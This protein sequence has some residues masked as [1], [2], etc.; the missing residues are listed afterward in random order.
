MPELLDI[1]FEAESRFYVRKLIDLANNRNISCATSRYREQPVSLNKNQISMIEVGLYQVESES[2]PGTFYSVCITSGTCEC[3]QGRNRGP[4]KH[5]AAIH[6]YYGE[7][8]FNV[9]P[10]HDPVS[11]RLWNF[12]A[13]GKWLPETWF[14][15]FRDSGAPETTQSPEE[16]AG[17]DVVED[18]NDEDDDDNNL[19]LE[20]DGEE[21]DDII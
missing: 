7:A 16:I 1:L 3:P 2:N 15:N 6:H 14:R 10:T 8:Q 4:C 17:E 12:I 21:D 11:R 13:T 19:N 5:K 20:D 18:D 9:V